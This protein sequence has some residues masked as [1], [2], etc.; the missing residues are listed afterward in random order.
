MAAPQN[1]NRAEQAFLEELRRAR[2]DG[3]TVEEVAEA[4]KGLLQARAVERSQD[5]AVASRWVSFLDLGRDWQFSKDFEDK[6]MA[7][8]PE[9][10]NAAFRKYIDPEQLTLVV[11]TDVSKGNAN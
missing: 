3:F 2:T 4:K 6:I 8:T 11:A 5:G 7:L 9:R 1:T 10:V